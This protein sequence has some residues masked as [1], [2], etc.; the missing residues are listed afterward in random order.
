MKPTETQSEALI[1]NGVKETSGASA[2]E[3]STEFSLGNRL[4]IDEHGHAIPLTEA[5]QAADTEALLI[6]L[7]EMALIPDDP[8]GSDEA[9]WRAMDEAHPDRPMFKELFGK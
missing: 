2:I 4:Q 9:F 3:T 8:P 1:A 6:A 5:E 7:A